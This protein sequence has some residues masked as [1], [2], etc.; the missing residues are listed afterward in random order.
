MKNETVSRIILIL[1]IAAIIIFHSLKGTE[2][3]S[4]KIARTPREHKLIT[5]Q[6]QPTQVVFTSVK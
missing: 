6:Q 4:D 5:L 3:T 1:E 2:P